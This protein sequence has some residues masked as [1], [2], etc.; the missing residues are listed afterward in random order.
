[1]NF[2]LLNLKIEK[3]TINHSCQCTS[4]TDRDPSRQDAV[5]IFF[6][7]FVVRLVYFLVWI[8]IVSFWRLLVYIC[9]GEVVFVFHWSLDVRSNVSFLVVILTINWRVVFETFGPEFPWH[10]STLYCLLFLT[11]GSKDIGRGRGVFLGKFLFLLFFRNSLF[12]F[13]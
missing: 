5:S 13:S 1:M 11:V 9:G 8:C 2:T 10:V 3:F 12:V 4:I 6:R 7:I